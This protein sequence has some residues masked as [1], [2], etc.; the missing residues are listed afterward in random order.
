MNFRSIFLSLFFLAPA[1]VFAGEVSGTI[2]KDGVSLANQ[3]I[4]ITQGEKVIAVVTTDKNGYFSINIQQVGR[5]KLEIPGYDGASFEV[6]STNN[7]TSYVLS[8]VKVGDAWQ[9]KKQ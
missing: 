8:L 1:F 4:K 9:L 5:F 3:E 7:S 2:K 6:V